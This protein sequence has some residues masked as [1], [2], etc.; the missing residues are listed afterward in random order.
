MELRNIDNFVF[1]LRRRLKNVGSA[2]SIRTLRGLGYRME[3]EN[4]KASAKK[5]TSLAAVLTGAVVLALCLVSFLLIRNQYLQSRH[6]AFQ[7][8]AANI[9]TQWQLDGALSTQWLAA[10]M[11]TNG[12][13]I[14]LWDN[15]IPLDYGDTPLSLAVTLRDSA[16]RLPEKGAP[17]LYT[18][19]SLRCAWLEFSFPYG[20]RQLLV[21]QDTGPE[22]GYLL[23]LAL[24]FLLLALVGLGVEGL[25]CYIVTGRAIRPAQEA[26]ERQ[27]HFVAA[28][29][30]E[31]RS[32]LTVLR[33]GFG[34]IQAD[35]GQTE[36]TLSL[37]RREADRMSRL[38]DELL[39][40]AGG[41]S[42]RKNFRPAKVELDTLL[43]DF[44]DGLTPVAEKAGVYLEIRLPEEALEPVPA[45]E[46]RIRQLISIL[47]DNALRYAPRG[48]SV[49]LSLAQKNRRCILMVADHGPG[50]PDGEKGRIFDRFYRGD[51]SRTDRSHFGLGLSVARELAAIHSGRIA[52][53]DTPGG[54][55]T[56]TV[57]LPM[58][59]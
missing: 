53:S 3:A 18:S 41:G 36:H 27:E 4:T 33:T 24:L 20:T 9:R 50:V 28:A 51:V 37:M 22:A 31:L 47:V 54:G 45:D 16:P 48:S 58:E 49:E 13:S 6:L 38:V 1:L 5:L 35:P 8:N 43:I 46:D 29:S 19:G 21:W 2:V 23:R 15:G 44:V 57:V 56:F 42:L 26:M 25:L 14:A 40:L 30:H 32:P 55:A 10:N 17:V 11:E 39:L 7:L 59:P 34:V 52:V 12:V